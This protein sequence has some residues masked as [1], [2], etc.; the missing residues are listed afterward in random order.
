MSCCHKFKSHT[1]WELVAHKQRT[2]HLLGRSGRQKF[3]SLRDCFCAKSSLYTFHVSIF[4]MLTQW[5][6]NPPKQILSFCCGT[7][8]TS[9]T[10]FFRKSIGNLIF[11]FRITQ[12]VKS[13]L[14]SVIVSFGDFAFS[15]HCKKQLLHW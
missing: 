13:S 2:R 10:A 1:V 7:T 14:P 4:F 5:I 12:T 9:D 15:C 6:P 11:K 3:L 8:E